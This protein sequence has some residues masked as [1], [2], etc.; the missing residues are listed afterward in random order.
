MSLLGVQ[1]CCC[2]RTNRSASPGPPTTPGSTRRRTGMPAC[3]RV[4]FSQTQTYPIEHFLANRDLY[5]ANTN[6]FRDAVRLFCISNTDISYRALFGRAR[7]RRKTLLNTVSDKYLSHRDKK[8]ALARNTCRI[9]TYFCFESLQPLMRLMLGSHATFVVRSRSCPRC[10]WQTMK[11]C[12][13]S[14]PRAT[15]TEVVMRGTKTPSRIPSMPF[16]KGTTGRWPPCVH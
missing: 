4:S 6:L 1:L 7:S 12:R 16:R 3:L 14:P 13:K 9:G 10:R 8:H 2:M 5:V 15:V 11:S